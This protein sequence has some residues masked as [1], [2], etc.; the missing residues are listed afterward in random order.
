MLLVSSISA[1]MIRNF[2]PD[3]LN[4]GEQ[5]ARSPGAEVA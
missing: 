1:T 4:N 3:L 5:F 2:A